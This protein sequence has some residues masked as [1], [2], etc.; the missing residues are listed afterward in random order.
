MKNAERIAKDAFCVIGKMGSTDDGPD[1]IQ[2]LWQDANGHF[3]QVEHLARRDGRGN[4]MGVWGI[5]TDF[6]FKF[7]PWEDD[8]SRG[9]YLAGVE[10]EPEAA[11]PRGW[12][13]WIVPG[14]E[15]W[16]I[17]VE[18]P[19][20]FRRT[21]AWMEERHQP[22]AGAVQDFTD[23]ATGE[24]YMLFPISGNHSK[25][26]LIRSVKDRTNPVGVCSIHCE[27]CF[28]SKW[29]G[30]CWSDCDVCSYATMF[31]DNICPNVRCAG[32][33]GFHSCSQCPELPECTLGFYQ[34]PNAATHKGTAL[35]VRR[36][37]EQA[38]TQALSHAIQAGV[39]YTGDLDGLN[40]PKKVC[41]L[42]EQYLK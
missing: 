20:T 33:K 10:A 5:M 19:D 15:Y 12:K 14:F 39:R 38:Y 29:C 18:G 16:K 11:A 36:H 34:Q 1:F 23:P 32:E 28:L 27:F 9:L 25:E 22:L 4:L 24:N 37:G 17:K 42:L 30:G 8:F 13:K 26:A 31:E 7:Q 35:F 2:R 6:G 21:I 3:D 40:D 41:A